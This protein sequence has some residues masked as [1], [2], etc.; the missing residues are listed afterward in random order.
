M[1]VQLCAASGAALGR[2]LTS[3]AR[4]LIR[5]ESPGLLETATAGE[6]N[7]TQ[8]QVLTPRRNQGDYAPVDTLTPDTIQKIVSAFAEHV[9]SDA[10]RY[11]G[12]LDSAAAR[13]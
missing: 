2:T 12:G 13:T 9:S 3:A 8:Q 5:R 6:L 4:R 1:H 10:F 11:S 7:F